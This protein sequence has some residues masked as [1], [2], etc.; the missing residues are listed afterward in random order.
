VIC[1]ISSS[2]LHRLKEDVKLCVDSR[3]PPVAEED[4]TFSGSVSMNRYE[5]EKNESSELDDVASLQ[6]VLSVFSL[7]RIDA[8]CSEK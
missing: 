8:S 3:R 2:A 4:H 5:S 6:D 1:D 7:E